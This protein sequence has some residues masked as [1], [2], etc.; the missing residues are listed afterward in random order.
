M[1]EHWTLKR[2]REREREREESYSF[3]ITKS[4]EIPCVVVGSGRIIVHS[5]WTFLRK[6][7]QQRVTVLEAFLTLEMPAHDLSGTGTFT[8]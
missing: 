4:Y 3:H 6:N 7:R 2:E 5:L 1:R 8:I